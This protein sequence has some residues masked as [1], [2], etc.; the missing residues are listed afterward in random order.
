M[1]LTQW[2]ILVVALYILVITAVHF[3][4]MFKPKETFTWLDTMNLL[5]L[6]ILTFMFFSFFF[7]AIF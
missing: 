1:Y 7:K 5:L 3:V 6:V 2:Q 4:S